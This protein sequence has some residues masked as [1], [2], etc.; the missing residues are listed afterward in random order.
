M[1]SSERARLTYKQGRC[2]LSIDG[3]RLEDEAEYKCEASNAAGITSTYMQLLVESKVVFSPC[4]RPTALVAR[5]Y[6][7]R[8]RTSCEVAMCA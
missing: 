5:L 8:C 7:H 2:V 6:Y 3:L 4:R 1:T